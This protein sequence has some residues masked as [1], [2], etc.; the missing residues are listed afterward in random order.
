[1]LLLFLSLF[2]IEEEK[3]E[4][5]GKKMFDGNK[6]RHSIIRCGNDQH[7]SV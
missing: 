1:L 5:E 6:H 2:N 4:E 7:E 3:E